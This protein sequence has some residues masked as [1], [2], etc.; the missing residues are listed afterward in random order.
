MTAADEA[1]LSE[2]AL[3]RMEALGETLNQVATTLNTVRERER[4]TRRLAIGLVISVFLD[5]ALTV[6]VS[7]LS[8][9]ALSQN[10]NLHQSQLAACAIGNQFRTQQVQLWDYLFQL[11]GGVKTAQERQLQ[12]YVEKTFSPV[13]CARLY[14]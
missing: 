2:A 11:S 10:S 8:V 4:T 5:V 9:N 12:T 7:I 14:H 1:P 13:D 3:A 6:V